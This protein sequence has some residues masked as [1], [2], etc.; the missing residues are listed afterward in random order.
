MA[1]LYSTFK[2]IYSSYL[3]KLNQSRFKLIF[4]FKFSKFIIQFFIFK[5]DNWIH[6][7]KTC[8]FSINYLK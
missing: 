4:L 1:I 3:N 6:K 5:L 2:F 8:F 7:D